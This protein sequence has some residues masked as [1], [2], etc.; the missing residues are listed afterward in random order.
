MNAKEKRAK[1]VEFIDK[2]TK[3]NK[4]YE[5]YLKPKVD[6]E[7]ELEKEKKVEEK[8][9]VKLSPKAQKAK[10]LIDSGTF[11]CQSR[12]VASIVSTLLDEKIVCGKDEDGEDDISVWDYS[13]WNITDVK[14]K[15]FSAFIELEGCENYELSTELVVIHYKDDECIQSIESNELDDG[16]EFYCYATTEEIKKYIADFS[17]EVMDDIFDFLF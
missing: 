6:I 4:N 9:E 13:N 16:Y 8:S 1:I 17:I 2:V 7:K 15:N 12:A 11:G 10:K 5:K 14:P 3:S